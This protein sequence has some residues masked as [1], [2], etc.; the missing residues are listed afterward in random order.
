[1]NINFVVVVVVVSFQRVTFTFQLHVNPR[2]FQIK[3]KKKFKNAI[4]NCMATKKRT[5]KNKKN[6]NSNNKKMWLSF[7]NIIV[8]NITMW[9]DTVGKGVTEKNNIKGSFQNFEKK[10][11]LKSIL[12]QLLHPSRS[13]TWK[14][15]PFPRTFVIDS[16]L[17]YI[18]IIE[19]WISLTYT[20]ANIVI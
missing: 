2:M 18:F 9:T 16:A 5:K 7:S 6:R 12:F 19:Y 13:F 14:C 4:K 10:S 11:V 17:S 8:Y 3:K 20:K 15:V 1:M